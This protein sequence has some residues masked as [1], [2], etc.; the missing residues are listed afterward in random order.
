MR[1]MYKG[2]SLLL[3]LLLHGWTASAQVRNKPDLVVMTDGQGITGLVVDVDLK[4]KLTLILPDATLIELPID[5]VSQVIRAAR[6]TMSDDPLRTAWLEAQRGHSSNGSGKREKQQQADRAYLA[7]LNIN[8]TYLSFSLGTVHGYRFNN[9]HQLG[10]GFLLDMTNRSVSFIPDRHNG[11][12]DQIEGFN[13]PVFVQYGGQ[14]PGRSVL[15][16]YNV[17][18]GYAFNVAQFSN[19][20]FRPLGMGGYHLAT[21]VGFRFLSPNRYSMVLAMRVGLRGY[22]MQFREYTTDPDKG[23]LVMHDNI[24]HFSALFLGI[25]IIHS[26]R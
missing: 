22:E 14:L 2:L 4:D 15:P 8:F 12:Q 5:S 24:R 1:A 11:R 23:I 25:S 10:L 20:V 13:I 19:H 17:E 26:F 18:A 9:W 21:S 3:V 7:Q 16:Y 6:A